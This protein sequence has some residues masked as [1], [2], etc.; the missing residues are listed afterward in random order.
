[1]KIVDTHTKKRLIKEFDGYPKVIEQYGVGSSRKKRIF[2]ETET[3]RVLGTNVELAN[4]YAAKRVNTQTRTVGTGRAWRWNAIGRHVSTHINELIEMEWE[5]EDEKEAEDDVVYRTHDL[6]R[7][8]DKLGDKFKRLDRG[9]QTSGTRTG[10]GTG[11]TFHG[12]GKNFMYP[13]IFLDNAYW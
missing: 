6:R 5:I 11:E 2:S 1:M 12:V 3:M 13:Y 8:T 10:L 9:R 7:W 4:A